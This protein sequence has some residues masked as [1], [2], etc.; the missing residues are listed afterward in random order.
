MLVLVVLTF[1]RPELYSSQE[2]KK[3]IEAIT[4]QDL[5]KVRLNDG[6]VKLFYYPKIDI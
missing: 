2:K 3:K 6:M 4:V 5:T 1:N